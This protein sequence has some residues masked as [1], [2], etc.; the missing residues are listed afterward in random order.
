MT[1]WLKW[2]QYF[3]HP[4]IPWSESFPLFL[5]EGFPFPTWIICLCHFSIS[6][7][8]QSLEQWD[9]Q[10]HLQTHVVGLVDQ[11]KSNHWDLWDIPLISLKYIW[12]LWERPANVHISP[13]VFTASETWWCLM[14]SSVLQ[15]STSTEDL[16]LCD[17]HHLLGREIKLRKRKLLRM[18]MKKIAH[19]FKTSCHYCCPTGKENTVPV[20]KSFIPSFTKRK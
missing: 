3:T 4:A 17:T 6:K 20:L 16:G 19:V 1:M 9:I 10:T 14:S 13:V 12:A 11:A 5:S 8:S 7:I 18:I 15:Q 2:S